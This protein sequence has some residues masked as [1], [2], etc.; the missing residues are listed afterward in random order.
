MRISASGKESGLFK[1]MGWNVQCPCCYVQAG[2]T[3][4]YTLPI[5]LAFWWSAVR[6]VGL[7]FCS[8]GRQTLHRKGRERER[9]R[10]TAEAKE[11]RRLSKTGHEPCIAL[12]LRGWGARFPIPKRPAS[13]HASKKGLSGAAGGLGQK[14]EHRRVLSC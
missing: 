9:E 1:K 12:L 3:C 13:K 14:L 8:F 5:C 10:E 11:R 4:V 2:A 6:I 7:S